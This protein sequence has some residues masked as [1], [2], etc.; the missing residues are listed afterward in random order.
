V[1]AYG[2]LP[3]S[4]L[5]NGIMYL[6]T[7]YSP[8]QLSTD[9][10]IIHIYLFLMVKVFVI[11]NLYYNNKLRW[12]VA[13]IFKCNFIHILLAKYIGTATYSFLSDYMY[14]IFAILGGG[15]LLLTGIL[16]YRKG[17]KNE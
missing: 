8:R 15:C 1:R 7:Q 14:I 17:I 16:L 11:K 10:F 13:Y 3:I 12:Q 4:N 5:V 9:L 6:E 2:L